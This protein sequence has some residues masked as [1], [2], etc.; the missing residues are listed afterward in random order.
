MTRE[1]KDAI[2]SFIR[3]LIRVLIP[4]NRK[5]IVFDN[6]A[7]RG[8]GDN[9]KY[10]AESLLS[11]NESFDLVWLVKD[12]SYEMPRGIRKVKHS[13]L[14]ASYELLTAFLWIDNIKNG[15]LEKKRKK[16]KYIQTWHGGNIP[17]K[18]I[19]GE[20]EDYL[21]QD[22]L[23]SSKLDSKQTDYIL[24]NSDLRSS[25]YRNS[26]WLN[27][28]C[29]IL[30][31]GIPRNDVYFNAGI[32]KI[33]NIKSKLFDSDRVSVLTYAPTFRDNGSMDAYNIDVEALRKVLID[34]FGGDWR[35]V[36]RLHP[37]VAKKSDIFVYNDYI[38]NGSNISD[39]QELFLISDILISDYS[40][41]ICDFMLMKKPVFLYVPDLDDY[42]RSC[43]DLRPIYH[44]LPFDYC[45]DNKSLL[46]SIIEFSRDSYLHSL[47]DFL[48][49]K[50]KFFDDGNA[51]RKV[52]DLILKLY[53]SYE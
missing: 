20:C 26:F 7:G 8:Y 53:Q 44:E 6:F 43:R 35:I 25:I 41:C 23:V 38:I 45:K 28:S 37:N 13:S 32:E 12:L 16:Q 21:S 29:E 50:C 9:P 49:K 3:L 18:L 33:R 22:Y 39:P 14:K 36:L 5:K 2:K 42:V 27:D 51:S 46:D 47:D 24:S 31:F 52:V 19:E 48:S 1:I 30:E 11:R 10:I 15:I 40:S 17:F 34:K 4:I